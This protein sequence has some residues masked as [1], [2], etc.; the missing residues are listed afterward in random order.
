MTESKLAFSTTVA[1]LQ[2][3]KYH[4]QKTKFSSTTR[5]TCCIKPDSELEPGD[6]SAIYRILP[7]NLPECKRPPSPPRH[8]SIPVIGFFIE[9][10]MGVLGDKSKQ[11]GTIYTSNFFI[12]NRAYISDYRTIIQILRDS[13]TFTCRGAF[14][15]FESIFGLDVVMVQDGVEHAKSRA[16]LA[17]AFATPLLPHYF[18]RILHISKITWNRVEHLNRCGK[19]VK[20]ETILREH[21]LAITVE[22]TTGIVMKGE[23]AIL[24]RDLYD[25]IQAAFLS[26][27]F[28]PIWNCGRRA[29]DQLLQLLVD[30]VRNDLKYRAVTIEK[31]R[32]YGDNLVKFGLKDLARGDSDVHMLLISIANSSLETGDN[33]NI[34]Q[35]VVEYLCRSIMLLFFASYATSSATSMCASFEIGLDDSIRAK[36]VAEQIAIVESANLPDN[37]VTYEQVASEMP[38]L[39]SFLNEILRLRPAAVGVNR[40]ITRDVEILGYYL[41]KDTVVFCDFMAAMRNPHIYPQPDTLIVDRFLNKTPSILSF[42][43]PGSAHYCIGAAF[44]KLMMKTTFATLLRHYHYT[45][46]SS[47]SR[48]YRIIPESTPQSGVIIDKFYSTFP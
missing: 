8:Y 7:D 9:K 25:K 27:P 18:N 5:T 4:N 10:A 40:R 16:T 47:Q 41:P 44:A 12:N 42:G 20:L 48:K 17:P 45:L 26:P 29:F 24:I 23:N 33:A 28:G 46:D 39:D 35:D 2:S 14:D 15:T 31:L 21:Y 37:S 3:F 38:L 11:Y 30:V 13:N 43:A 22:T 19:Q 32:Q 1:P 34:N 36:L 6:A